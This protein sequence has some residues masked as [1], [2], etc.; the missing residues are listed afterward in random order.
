MV[1]EAE[2]FAAL[3]KT[4]CAPDFPLEAHFH[5]K[6]L[7]FCGKAELFSAE[8]GRV[9]SWMDRVGSELNSLGLSS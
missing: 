3:S 5:L 7:D 4:L 9:T 8:R 6:Y 1:T 2:V